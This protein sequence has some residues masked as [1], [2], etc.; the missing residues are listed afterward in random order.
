[1]ALGWLACAGCAAATSASVEGAARQPGS[2]LAPS[3]PSMACVSP[4]EPALDRPSPWQEDLGKRLDGALLGLGSCDAGLGPGDE[5]ELAL[6][7]LYE[8]D[9]SPIA[10]HVISADAAACGAAD[11]LRQRLAGVYAAASTAASGFFDVGLVL[12]GGAA[13]RRSDAPVDPLGPDGDAAACVDP[14]VA[15]LSRRAVRDIVGTSHDA[16]MAC[17]DQALGRDQSAAGSVTFEL[18]IDRSGEV[19]RALARDAT[20]YDCPAIECMLDQLAGLSFPKPVGRGVRVLYPV[21]YSLEQ[22][23]VSLR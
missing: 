7:L 20:L 17:Y 8:K 13:P 18:R 19:E 11:C 5:A 23:P 21:E 12:T 6:R 4:L 3:D 1:V 14:E 22:A 15:R 16:L 10:Q 9:G 2:A